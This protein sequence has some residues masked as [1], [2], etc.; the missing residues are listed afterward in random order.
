MNIEEKVDS[1]ISLNEYLLHENDLLEAFISRI[2]AMKMP[3]EERIKVENA[4]SRHGKT[5]VEHIEKHLICSFEAEKL[6]SD[7]ESIKKQGTKTLTVFKSL[8]IV[9]Q[10]QMAFQRRALNDF[11]R[12]LSQEGSTTITAD[13]AITHL[14]ESQK[15]QETDISKLELKIKAAETR[16]KTLKG[17]SRARHEGGEPI[18]VIDFDQLQIENQQLSD[19]IKERNRDLLELKKTSG[20]VTENLTKV[21]LSLQSLASEASWLRKEI[22]ARTHAIQKGSTD[23]LTVKRQ[24]SVAESQ[25]KQF[26]RRELSGDG[27]EVIH[28]IR[29]KA[30]EGKYKRSVKEWERKLQ[31]AKLCAKSKPRTI[32]T[33]PYE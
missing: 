21:K 11:R 20:N 4:L 8:K 9:S 28:Y 2:S 24:L 7:I 26:K 25:F 10:E 3:A 13:K 33:E 31:I 6:R 23:M 30:E 27:P 5:P 22:A 14:I 15:R 1:I 16:L 32:E 17:Q 29:V 12:L 19:R 18:H